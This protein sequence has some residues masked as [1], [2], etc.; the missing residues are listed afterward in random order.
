M[1]KLSHLL[2]L[3]SLWLTLAVTLSLEVMKL[4]L[5]E[6]RKSPRLTCKKKKDNMWN[7]RSMIDYTL[8]RISYLKSDSK[9]RCGGPDSG[10]ENM[11]PFGLKKVGFL[12]FS[13]RP[14]T[15]NYFCI[16]LCSYQPWYWRSLVIMRPYEES[17]GTDKT[18][19]E[20]RK[21]PLNPLNALSHKGTQT[22]FEWLHHW[23]K[24]LSCPLAIINCQ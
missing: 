23:R 7:Y 3:S 2:L 21:K 11:L 15:S 10:W 19:T 5:T 18:W 14:K 22:T 8:S 24:R 13:L 12:L 16:F 17:E 4:M 1:C 6:I 9:L 20:K